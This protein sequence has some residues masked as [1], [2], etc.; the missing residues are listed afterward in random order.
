MVDDGPE[1]T[2]EGTRER[3]KECTKE[4][5][6]GH[7]IYLLFTFHLPLLLCALKNWSSVNNLTIL[8]TSA[9][10]LLLC[11]GGAGIGIE[12]RGRRRFMFLWGSVIGSMRVWEGKLRGKLREKAEP[13]SCYRLQL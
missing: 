5:S 3:T 7:L 6:S 11:V 13:T 10:P 8:L 12:G 4:W 2:S 9:L 1:K